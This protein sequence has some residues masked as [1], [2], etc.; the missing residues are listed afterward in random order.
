M[1]DNKSEIEFHGEKGKLNFNMKHQ[2]YRREYGPYIVD[3][4]NLATLSPRCL[5]SPTVLKAYYRLLSEEYD[6]I[7]ALLQR[8]CPRLKIFNE[9]MERLVGQ[10]LGASSFKDIKFYMGEVENPGFGSLNCPPIFEYFDVML[11]PMQIECEHFALLVL[12]AEYS[13]ERGG[14]FRFKM[15]YMDSL[16]EEY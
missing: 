8:P 13:R 5:I 15:G 1:N 12:E 3:R 4:C 6:R 7:A 11:I 9:L 2:G 10:S 14:T 16:Q